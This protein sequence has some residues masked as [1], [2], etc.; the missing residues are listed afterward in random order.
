MGTLQIKG[1]TGGTV[2]EVET[3]T[4]ALRGVLKATTEPGA[5]SQ[6]MGVNL[7]LGIVAGA[8]TYNASPILSWRWSAAGYIG[9]IKR[10]NVS[11]APGSTAPAAQVVTVGLFVVRS[12]K[13]QGFDLTTTGSPLPPVNLLGPPSPGRSAF[14]VSLQEE[15]PFFSDSGT[16]AFPAA[17]LSPSSYDFVGNAGGTDA[18]GTPGLK[19]PVATVMD[20]NAI[21]AITVSAKATIDPILRAA[22]LWD[23]SAGDYPLI[24]GPDMGFVIKLTYV[25]TGSSTVANQTIFGLTVNWEEHPVLSNI[26]Q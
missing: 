24:L 4:L 6:F 2:P 25:I 15:A 9:A 13:A 26:Y 23:A 10:I 19:M 14:P 7:P 11:L 1:K 5:S 17:G 8:T 20:T 16:A 3:A 21:A 22:P 18:G 12:Y